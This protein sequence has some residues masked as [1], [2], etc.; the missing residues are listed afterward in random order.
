MKKLIKKLGKKKTIIISI[1]LILAITG[2]IIFGVHS[3]NE[4]KKAE[5]KEYQKKS[6]EAV[7][8]VSTV[9][10]KEMVYAKGEKLSND[11]LDYIEDLPDDIDNTLLELDT[12]EVNTEEVGSYQYTITYYDNK[13]VSFVHIVEDKEAKKEKQKEIDAKVKEQKKAVQESLKELEK[14]EKEKNK[15]TDSTKK[16]DSSSKKTTTKPKLKEDSLWAN[17]DEEGPSGTPQTGNVTDVNIADYSYDPM[18]YNPSGVPVSMPN[19]NG[20]LW[21]VFSSPV[22]TDSFGAGAIT[23]WLPLANQE[24]QIWAVEKAK[25]VY[26]TNTNYCVEYTEL[27]YQKNKNKALLGVVLKASIGTKDSNDSCSVNKKI[28]YA[29]DRTKLTQDNQIFNFR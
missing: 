11:P 4:H 21:K 22:V 20:E 18:S 27:I 24:A 6:E 19:Y 23:N 2:G 9:A 12:S 7:K 5:E 13:M 25:Q 14:L 29:N 1:F 16:D 15:N 10:L 17:R 28:V 8:T 3:Y 26:G